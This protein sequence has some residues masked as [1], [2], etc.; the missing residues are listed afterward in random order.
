MAWAESSPNRAPN[1][2]SRG[3]R[4]HLTPCFGRQSVKKTQA[5]P[6]FSLDGAKRT[7]TADPLH[8][9]QVLYQLSYGPVWY[10]WRRERWS[11]S[12]D[13]MGLAWRELSLHRGGLG[14]SEGSDLPPDRHQLALHRHLLGR[15]HQGLVGGVGRFEGDGAALAM[16]VLERGAAAGH[17][18]ADDGAVAQA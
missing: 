1:G 11:F 12:L 10:A 14:L 18:G 17:Q 4:V 16:K 5:E 9:M 2:H 3:I 6:G 7:R 8:A 13:P 15:Q